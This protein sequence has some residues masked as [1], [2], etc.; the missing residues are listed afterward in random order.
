MSG[1]TIDPTLYRERDRVP[2]RRALV[3]VSGTDDLLEARLTATL[4][5]ELQHSVAEDRPRAAPLSQRALDL[6]RR[7]ADPDALYGCLLARHDVLWVPGAGEARSEVAR[8]MIDVALAAG[9]EE[10][11][12]E[13]LLL[14]ANAA[15]EQGSPSFGAALEWASRF[16]SAA[17]ESL[18][19]H[20]T[21]LALRLHEGLSALP[22]LTVLSPAGSPVI[23]VLPE[24]V[25]G[26][27]LATFLAKAGVS[28]RSG[29][30]CAHHWLIERRD[31]APLVRFSVG[32]HSTDADVDRALEVMTPLMKGL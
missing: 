16:R 7:A 18:E 2:I 27:R 4:A 23:S 31:L 11:H 12:A 3:A 17:G 30:F 28:V 13:G 32:A 20:E 1:A 29:Y 24:R 22:H 14:L 6:G 25:D 15:L 21:R 5:R 8:E 9:S 19:Q 26:H 10:R